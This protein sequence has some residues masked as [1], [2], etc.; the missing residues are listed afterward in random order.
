MPA[1]VLQT[2]QGR[3]K[4][5]LEPQRYAV[6]GKQPEGRGLQCGPQDVQP[7]VKVLFEVIPNDAR[8]DGAVRELRFQ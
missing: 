3:Y 6:T 8:G 7:S 4:L 5:V 2:S 1:I